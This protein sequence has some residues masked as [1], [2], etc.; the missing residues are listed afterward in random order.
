LQAVILNKATSLVVVASASPLRA[1]TVPF[2][3]VA[4]HWPIIVNL[5][6]GSLVG[7]WVGA[8]SA[9]RMKSK[10]LHRVIAVLLAIIAGVLLFAHDAVMGAPP[11]A[12]ATLIVAGIVA[13]FI[14]G[15]V[16]SLLGI[17]GGEFL[18]PVLVLLF[19]ADIKLAGSLS[20][21]VSLPTMLVGFTRY[22][23]DQSF[24][25]LRENRIFLFVMAAGSIVGTLIGGLLPGIVPTAVLL[26]MLAALLV[27][28]VVKVW[29]HRDHGG[30]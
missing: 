22:S 10:T 2:T 27:C 21:A 29:G 19:G 12:G 25:V 28:S 6:A 4:A 3:E 13:G 26:P 16:A 7:A 5:L 23:R 15:V 11:L 14:I 18:I 17:A 8:G 1:P 20:L 9:T 24:S 30:G